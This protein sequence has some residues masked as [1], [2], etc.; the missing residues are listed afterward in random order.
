[1]FGLIVTV[2][3]VGFA[4]N[5]AFGVKVYTSEIRLLTVDGLQVP[6]IPLVEDV[7]N[8]GTDPPEQIV[9]LVPKV[10]DG[11]VRGVTLIVMFVGTVH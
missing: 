11:V 3:V 1:M 6:M 9:K 7:G 8:A 5:P 10:N 2:N 4:H